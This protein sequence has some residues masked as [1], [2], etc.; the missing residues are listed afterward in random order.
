MRN[1]LKNIIKK[2]I[3]WPHSRPFLIFT[4]Q[5]LGLYNIAKKI[6]I[7]LRLALDP[8]HQE[9]DYSHLTTRELM[10]EVHQELKIKDRKDSVIFLKKL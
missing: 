4:A 9:I 8:S 10:D 3:N 7:H 2:T 1:L 6:F 5:R